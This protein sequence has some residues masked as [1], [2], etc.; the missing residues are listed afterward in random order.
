MKLLEKSMFFLTFVKRSTC[1]FIRTPYWYM[2]CSINLSFQ[3]LKS[4]KYWFYCVSSLLIYVCRTISGSESLVYSFVL[5][6]FELWFACH[7]IKPCN[8]FMKAC[9]S[10][11]WSFAGV[12]AFIFQYYIIHSEYICGMLIIFRDKL[13][14]LWLSWFLLFTEAFAMTP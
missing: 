6:K 7:V 10:S 11:V 3:Y 4:S 14:K 12:R 13:I 8:W 2:I 1:H 9:V 5:W